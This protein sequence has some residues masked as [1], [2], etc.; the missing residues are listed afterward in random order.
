MRSKQHLTSLERGASVT[1]GAIA[2]DPIS[3]LAKG[4]WAFQTKRGLPVCCN[5]HVEVERSPL[6]TSWM[7]PFHLKC[8]SEN[9]YGQEMET[10]ATVLWEGPVS[11]S[12]LLPRIFAVAK[13]KPHRI[14]A[15]SEL[16]AYGYIMLFTRGLCCHTPVND[17]GQDKVF[18]CLSGEGYQP[19]APRDTSRFYT[20][21]ERWVR[22]TLLE[23][24]T[25][26]SFT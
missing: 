4:A 12:T 10:P 20:V 18:A 11:S 2:F 8:V 3:H 24:E 16:V 6:H 22:A 25:R 14:T 9:F 7:Y 26:P 5:F 13:E 23:M 21:F 19:W 1:V 15:N 17:H